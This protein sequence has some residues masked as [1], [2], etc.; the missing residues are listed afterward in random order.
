M[1]RIPL[2]IR[3]VTKLECLLVMLIPEEVVTELGDADALEVAEVVRNCPV[4]EIVMVSQLGCDLMQPN[5]PSS[6]SNSLGIGGRPL[7]QMMISADS[8]GELHSEQWL[9]SRML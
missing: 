4:V 2:T 5:H 6:P 9:T 3:T 1:A 7:A 8:G